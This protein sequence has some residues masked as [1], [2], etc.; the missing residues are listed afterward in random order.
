[1]PTKHVDI[2]TRADA[3]VTSDSP[4]KHIMDSS[5]TAWVGHGHGQT[6]WQGRARN[7]L[8]SISSEMPLSSI[9]R[10]RRVFLAE[11]YRSQVIYWSSTLEKDLCTGHTGSC[12]SNNMHIWTV[13]TWLRH[14]P[15]SISPAPIENLILL[16]W[17]YNQCASARAPHDSY[18][19]TR[20]ARRSPL[21]FLLCIPPQMYTN[22]LKATIGSR[23]FVMSVSAVMEG[24]GGVFESD[25]GCGGFGHFTPTSQLL[26]SSEPCVTASTL[27]CHFHSN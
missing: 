7:N 2:S 6:G 24:G 5:Y 8:A 11:L 20:G 15:V 25:G 4:E 13:R 21:C 23:P 9:I 17:T 22:L 16:T 1:M 12:G 3:V 27:R 26:F 18:S 14:P 19:V 10:L